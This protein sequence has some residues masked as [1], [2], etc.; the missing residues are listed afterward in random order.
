MLPAQ[1]AEQH[2]ATAA[3]TFVEWACC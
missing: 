1:T 2:T 3:W